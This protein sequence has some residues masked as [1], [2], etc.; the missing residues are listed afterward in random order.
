MARFAGGPGIDVARRPVLVTA[1]VAACLLAGFPPAATAQTMPGPAW[2]ALM[3]AG[4]TRVAERL[5]DELDPRADPDGDAA[6]DLLRA[7]ERATG[8]PDGG[9]EWLAV[10][11]LWLRAGE[12]AAAREALDR[13]DEEVPEGLRLLDRARIGFLA[14]EDGA[15]RLWWRACE[16]A[17]EAA[18]L[19]AWLDLE[20][21]ATPGE[22]AAWDAHRRLPAGPRDDCAWF[23]RFL[24]RRALASATPVDARLAEHYARLRYAR[25]RYRRRGK[26]SGT[27]ARREGLPVGP[28]F[29]DRGLLFL[30]MGP[31]DRTAS[32]GQGE[33][34]EPNVTWAYD[35]PGGP[36]LYHLSPL[37]GTD[38]WW[39]LENLARVFRCPVDPASGLVIRTRDPF[40]APP[41]PLGL[42]PG[43]L[44]HDLYLSRSGLDPEYARMASRFG[45]TR[46]LEELQ[47]EREM[48]T[49]DLDAL[50]DGVPERPAVDLALGLRH[51]WLQFRSPRPGE[52]E[53][54]LNAE[55]P[56]ADLRV[57]GAPRLAADLALLDESGERLVLVSGP[58]TVAPEGA[59]DGGAIALRAPAALGPGTWRATLVVRELDGGDPPRGTWVGDSVVV[60]D[61][62]GTLP[63]LSDV[64]V[65]PDSGGAWEPRPGVRLRPSPSHRS[66]PGRAWIYLE[67]YNLTPGG[68][69]ETLATLEAE[70]VADGRAAFRQTWTG[71]ASRGGRVVTP[72]L[73]R[74]D[75]G[76]TAPGRY[77]LSVTVTDLATGVR[78]LAARTALEVGGAG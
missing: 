23:R 40:V 8:G 24:N 58:A 69:F 31:P 62:G 9:W 68:A 30:R 17:D 34:F 15:A 75:L 14:G 63:Q 41:P 11:R 6:R 16:V 20:P 47:R 54:W 42:V 5:S 22:A 4:A 38:D 67:A 55:V 7:W 60:R 10:S 74:L 44:L 52:T 43:W 35:E 18:A 39:L 26:E 66:G 45:G 50:V 1:L 33:C 32:Y 13:V 53:V 51:E 46:T 56:A 27:L 36:R 2:H 70:E 61:L 21:L 29:D 59:G 78:T 57:P 48:T 71:T 25:D 49:A 72:L 12:P 73:L 37:G 3:D 76:A 77:R 19:E 64:A 65:A 28:A